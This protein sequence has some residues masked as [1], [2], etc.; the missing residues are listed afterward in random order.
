MDITGSARMRHGA[1]AFSSL[2]GVVRSVGLLEEIAVGSPFVA[3]IREDLPIG[4]Y[5]A[6]DFGRMALEV[7]KA[8]W[9]KPAFLIDRN[10]NAARSHPAFDGIPV[11]GPDE[12]PGTLK[13]QAQILVTVAT[14]AYAPIE[15]TL[16][17]HGFQHVAPFYDFSERF[18]HIHPLSNGWRL[19]TLTSH[20][21]A[22]IAHV[23]QGLEDDASRAHYLQFLAWRRLRQEWT[24][25]GAP[26][27]ASSR[28]FIPDVEALLTS[29]E[30]LVDAGA[31]RGSVSVDFA[32]RRPDWA[33]IAA[34]EPDP[35][36][37]ADME[38][39]FAAA[40]PDEKRQPQTFDCALG[41]A[42]GEAPFHHGLGYASQ[43]SVTGG[44]MAQ[45]RAL[46][47]LDLAPT[48]LKLHLE[49]GE[50]DALKGASQTL[51]KRRPIVTATIYHNDDGVWRTPLYL[52]QTL[53]DYRYLLRLHAWCGTGTVLY[54]LPRERSDT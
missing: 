13:Q 22:M 50:L 34:I 9:I 1:R 20:D 44:L 32:R 21:Q 47:D 43:L 38:Q 27:D 45:L 52:M 23:L 31:Y 49:G 37:R 18:R 5:G 28:Y 35:L 17:E 16:F 8:L 36:N 29:G 33:S 51:A 3:P 14:A 2:P 42:N 19:E 12:T 4:L 40:F 54:A 53:K 26:I 24:F 15:N 39:A 30:R 25:D 46:D 11:Y 10:P 6:G 7:L 48:F 41:A